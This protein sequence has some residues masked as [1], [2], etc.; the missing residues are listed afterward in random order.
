MC[1]RFALAAPAAELITRFG[2]DQCADFGRRNN[3]APGTD[4][5]V[6]RESAEGKRLLQLFRWGLVP[7][8][9]KDPS[10][11]ARLNNARAESVA[12]KPAFRDAF[13]HRRCLIPASGFFEWK[14]EGKMKQPYY[15]RPPGDADV[16]ALAGLVERWISPGGEALLTCCIITTEANALLAPI[17]DRMPAIISPPDFAA[18]M[19]RGHTDV[20]ALRGLLRPAADGGMM[21]YKV[22]RAV[23]SSRDDSPALVLPE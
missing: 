16:F 13:K 4:I 21:A 17:H 18:W 10:I 5:P 3:I 9:A 8:W 22:S 20:E 12:E 2:L 15:I 7:H 14:A 19:D 1:G 6:I 11:G 23:N